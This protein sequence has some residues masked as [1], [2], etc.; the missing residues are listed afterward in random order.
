[1]SDSGGQTSDSGRPRTGLV[2]VVKEDC[3]A[4]RL[5]EPVLHRLSAGDAE[6]VVYSQDDPGFPADIEG[7]ID[8]RSLEHSFHL[9]IET[10]PTLIRFAK[11]VEVERAVGWNRTDWERLT[12]VD[13]LGEGLPPHRP[14]CGSKSVEPGVPEV[15][16]VRYGD[17]GLGSRHIDVPEFADPME[18]C[19]DRGWTDGLPVVPPTPERVLRMLAG[20]PRPAE[21]MI[22]RIPPDLVECTVEK[23]AVNAVLAG[24]KPEYMPL[25][26]G[27]VEAALEPGFTLHA[28]LCSTCFSAPVIIVNGP[29][30]R[31]LDMNSGINVLGQGNRANATIGRALNL[32]VQNVG[33][34]RPGDID[35]AT[36]GSASKFTQCFAEDESDPEW[37]P[38]ATSRG[39]APGRDAVTLFQ[40]EGVQGFVDQRSRTPEE[41]VRSLAMSLVSVGHP[42]LCE[43]A[44]TL[45]LLS[46]E[47]YAIFRDAGW[48]RARITR[49]LLDATT[50]P[51]RDLVRGADGVGE[52]VPPS[53]ADEMIPK[54]PPDGLLIA[55]AG[56]PAGLF[57]AILPGWPGGSAHEHSHPVTK[58]IRT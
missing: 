28:V 51:G 32:I 42:K 20:T 30:A 18:T 57:S 49:A 2:A 43:W 44:F 19:F 12:A 50:R 41:L 15:L 56:G 26:L 6:I 23:V 3:P 52:G 24:C 47:H 37:E 48:D 54:F 40:G 8:D 46:P 11:G 13:G 25:L 34:G 31:R 53:R 35:R 39:I 5:V 17:T 55:R 45:L 14:G 21:E 4:C 27:I 10:V 16:Q 38:L 29:V 33:G 22:G 36:F 58:E 1:M 9:G 7:V